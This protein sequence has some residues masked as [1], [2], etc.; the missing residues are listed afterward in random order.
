MYLRQK[1]RRWVFAVSQIGRLDQIIVE[2]QFGE[3]MEH[4]D[5]TTESVCTNLKGGLVRRERVLPI[6]P[7]I[8]FPRSRVTEIMFAVVENY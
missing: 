1:R 2:R 3:M 8:D 5:P 7:R 6:K 4:E